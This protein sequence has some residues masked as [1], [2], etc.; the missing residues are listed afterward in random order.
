MT[1]ATAAYLGAVNAASDTSLGEALVL[2]NEALFARMS[3]ASI[4]SSSLRAVASSTPTQATTSPT[5][6]AVVVAIAMS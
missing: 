4:A 6:S 1:T 2:A 5:C 3:P